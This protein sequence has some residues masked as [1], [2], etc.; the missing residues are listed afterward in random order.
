MARLSRELEASIL[1]T[2]ASHVVKQN[3][4]Q[5]TEYTQ[6]FSWPTAKR[7]QVRQELREI[8]PDLRWQPSQFINYEAQQAPLAYILLAI[9]ERLFARIPLPTRVLILRIC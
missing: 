6:Y 4:P 9:P 2:P 1:L 8:P 3:L 7:L 5:V